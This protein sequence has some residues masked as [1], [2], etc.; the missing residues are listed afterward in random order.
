[1]KTHP[2]L[3]NWYYEEDEAC[4]SYAVG[5][6]Y[7]H[8]RMRDGTKMKVEIIDENGDG[9]IA[10]DWGTFKLGRPIEKN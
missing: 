1:M 5:E 2:S 10:T 9:V 3:E 6:V 8:P 7:E 4:V